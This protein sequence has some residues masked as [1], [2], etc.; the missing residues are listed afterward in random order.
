VFVWRTHGWPR[1]IERVDLAEPHQRTEIFP[2]DLPDKPE[3]VEVA[4]DGTA[5]TIGY[6]WVE[7]SSD[8]FV[9]EPP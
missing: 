9:L 2:F 4:I 5:S 7:V 8:L 3:H 6:S 1:P